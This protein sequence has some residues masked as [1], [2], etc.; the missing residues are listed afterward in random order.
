MGTELQLH[1]EI[2][3]IARAS[4]RLAATAKN[5]ARRARCFGRNLRVLK[6]FSSSSSWSAC[7]GRIPVTVSLRDDDEEGK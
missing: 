2:G 1:R 3:A 6:V 5:K 4:E 7:C